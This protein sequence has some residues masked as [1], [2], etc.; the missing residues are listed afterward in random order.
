MHGTELMTPKHFRQLV[1]ALAGGLIIFV[2]VRRFGRLVALRG[3]RDTRSEPLVIDWQPQISGNL[4]PAKSATPSMPD[5]LQFSDLDQQR[6]VSDEDDDQGPNS[7]QRK[8]SRARQISFRGRRY[9]PLPEEL[10]GRRVEVLL[11][12][13]QIDIVHEGASIASF[14][15]L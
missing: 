9:G 10:V 2:V 1:M 15:L 7:Y 3:M 14:D 8:V 6:D 11:R 4:N 13:D 5:D 12:D